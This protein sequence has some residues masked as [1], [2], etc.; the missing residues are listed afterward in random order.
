MLEIGTLAGYSTLFLAKGLLDD[1]SSK[2]VTLEYD[3]QIAKVAH[4]ILKK[5]PYK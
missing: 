5:A 2:V 3:P 4:K 1:D